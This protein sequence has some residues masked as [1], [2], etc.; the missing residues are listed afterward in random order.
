[1]DPMTASALKI[2]PTLA[3]FFVFVLVCIWGEGDMLVCMQVPVERI[4]IFFYCSQSY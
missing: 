1:M 3:G 4:G 2:F